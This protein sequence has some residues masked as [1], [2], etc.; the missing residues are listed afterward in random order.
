MMTMDLAK[1]ANTFLETAQGILQDVRSHALSGEVNFA[2]SVKLASMMDGAAATTGS[3][4]PAG[5][6]LGAISG[7]SAKLAAPRQINFYHG[8]ELATT[9]NETATEAEKKPEVLGAAG[10]KVFG[11]DNSSIVG[12]MGFEK[13]EPTFLGIPFPILMFFGVVCGCALCITTGCLIA[14]NTD[15]LKVN[16]DKKAADAEEDEDDDDDEDDEKSY[17]WRNQNKEA[18]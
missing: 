10:A 1:T 4:K 2:K 11:G 3:G 6:I 16:V 9:G 18:V 5:G 8:E 7:D 15:V 13:K 12:F 14:R 17:Y